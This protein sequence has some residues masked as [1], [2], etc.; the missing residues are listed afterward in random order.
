MVQFINNCLEETYS[1][2]GTL[3]GSPDF[4]ELGQENSRRVQFEAL[5]THIASLVALVVDCLLCS[6]QI[7]CKLMEIIVH[8][9][10][11]KSE[12]LG[13]LIQQQIC[14]IIST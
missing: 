14:A 9:E 3:G 6:Y 4:G 7:L 10:K 11:T 8:Q 1:L 5:L 12:L 13:G 2:W